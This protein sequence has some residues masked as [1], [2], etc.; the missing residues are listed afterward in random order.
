M[1]KAIH[2]LEYCPV[3]RLL[4][5]PG[6]VENAGIL[7]PFQDVFASHE[8]DPVQAV[9]GQVMVTVDV[10]ALSGELEEHLLVQIG[11]VGL[12]EFQ[13]FE[14]S[15]HI[16]RPEDVLQRR[17]VHLGSEALKLLGVI[18][19]T[20]RRDHGRLDLVWFDYFDLLARLRLQISVLHLTAQ[21]GSGGRL[22][23]WRLI[24]DVQR[25]EVRLLIVVT[26]EVVRI[27]EVQILSIH[28]QQQD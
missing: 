19:H 24:A 12:V 8:R 22:Y 7:E 1:L 13:A 3:V 28:I 20:T 4:L 14:N 18:V 5:H 16:D 26:G 9:Q 25:V 15:L 2:H 17:I 11:D 27:A 10:D 23:G 6:R 21:H